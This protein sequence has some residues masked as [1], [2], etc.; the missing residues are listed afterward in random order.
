MV[1]P[2]AKAFMYHI[3]PCG[4]GNYHNNEVPLPSSLRRGETSD[5]LLHFF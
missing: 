3:L 2:S 4:Y 5:V 1:T